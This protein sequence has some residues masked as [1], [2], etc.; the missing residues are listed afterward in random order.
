MIALYY[1]IRSSILTFV[2]LFVAIFLFMSLL[3][4]SAND[5]SWSHA[6]NVASDVSNLAGQIGA[7][8]ADILY[9][10]LGGASWWLVAIACYEGLRAWFRH[11]EPH[12]AL[13]TLGYVFLILS[14]GA[15]F[16]LMAVDWLAQGVFGQVVAQGLRNLLTSVGAFVFFMR[17]FCWLRL[18]LPLI[19][20]GKNVWQNGALANGYRLTMP[21]QRLVQN[22]KRQSN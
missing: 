7:W 3:S 20:I 13:R 19:W 5:P 9:T 10:F 8:V 16:G 1:Y 21:R 6:S 14:T 18:L 4:Y 11:T 22:P 12:G 15:L 17:I 2:W